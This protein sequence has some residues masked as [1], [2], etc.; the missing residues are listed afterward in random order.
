[1]SVDSSGRHGH[2]CRKSASRLSRHSAVNDLIKRALL[3]AEIPSKLQLTSLL[4]Q[5]ERRPD[6]MS[7]T[8]GR[9][10]N[11]WLGTSRAL[12]PS[13]LNNA[14]NGTD[15][16]A[17]KAEDKKRDKYANLAPSYCF[18]PVA[19]ETLGALGVGA[20]ELIHEL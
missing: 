12:A 9:T 3:L 8:R 2:S 15:I 6:G 20:V 18:Q 16:S 17:C 4:L 7:L 14:V 1:V 10:A 19:V 11:V 5:N 13:H